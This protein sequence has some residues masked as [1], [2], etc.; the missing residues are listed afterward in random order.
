MIVPFSLTLWLI[1]KKSTF[2][3]HAEKLVR[4]WF[5]KKGVFIDSDGNEIKWGYISKLV[6]FSQECELFTTHKLNQSHINWRRQP[7]NVRIAVETLSRSTADS[8]DF[9]RSKSYKHFEGSVPTTKFIRIFDNLFNVF[10]SKLIIAQNEFKSALNE[11]NKHTVFTFLDEVISYIKDL[12][13]KEE[14]GKVVSICRSSA[15][16]GFVGFIWNIYSLKSIFKEY[17]EEKKNLLIIPTYYLNQDA[18]EM[19]FGKVRSLGG[20]NDNPNDIQFTAAYKKL[21]G[22][23]SIL[24][25]RKGNCAPLLESN[26]NPFSSILYISSKRD[27]YVQKR[28]DENDIFVLQELEI[29]YEKLNKINSSVQSELTENMKP[30]TIGHIASIIEDKIKISSHCQKC[31]NVF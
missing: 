21:L 27:K 23:D 28:D 11:S 4:G 18:V 20:H 31:I 22:N 30:N 6:E 24:V 1:I 12:K 10:N 2:F 26:E 8:I 25:S 13:F 16:T 7:M 19:F 17:V 14:A 29:L 9:L 5:D 15:R 3:F